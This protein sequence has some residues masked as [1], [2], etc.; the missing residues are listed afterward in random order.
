MP[1]RK[2][3]AGAMALG[4][5]VLAFQN[6]GNLESPGDNSAMSATQ[7]SNLAGLPPSSGTSS[8]GGQIVCSLRTNSPRDYDPSTLLSCFG[9]SEAQAS[10]ES[11]VYT[12]YGNPTLHSQAFCAEGVRETN[13]PAEYRYSCRLL[14]RVATIMNPALNLMAFSTALGV[15]CV[16]NF[17]Y[18]ASTQTP[19][20]AFYGSPQGDGVSVAQF[21]YLCSVPATRASTAAAD[22]AAALANQLRVTALS[23]PGVTAAIPTLT[24]PTVPPSMTFVCSAETAF[25]ARQEGSFSLNCNATFERREAPPNPIIYDPPGSNV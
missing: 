2:L 14:R 11:K 24:C 5:L 25:G 22:M 15:R 13:R 17:A 23:C 12:G 9:P 1:N 6:C 8:L 7:A 10:I 16:A 3:F 20:S 4:L 19:N 18:A 21:S